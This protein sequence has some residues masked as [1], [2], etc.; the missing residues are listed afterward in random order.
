MKKDKTTNK[1][2]LKRAFYKG[3]AKKFKFLICLMLLFGIIASAFSFLRT[4]Y[5]EYAVSSAHVILNYPEISESKYPDGSRFTYY[6]FISDENLEKALSVM[7][8]NGKYLNFTVDDIREQFSIYSYLKGSAGASVSSARSEGNDFS[9]V[10]NEYRITFMQPHDYKSESVMSC[11]VSEDLSGEFLS[12]LVEVNRQKIAQT[13]GGAKGFE[14][15]TE[16]VC[17][18]NYDYIEEVSLYKTKINNII[19]YIRDLEKKQPDFIS[20]KHNLALN[21][22]RGSY[23][24]LISNSLEGIRDFVESSGISKD[25]DQTSNKIEVNIED[26]RLRFNK[27]SS[28]VVFNDFAMKNYD[29]TFTENLINVIQNEEYGLYQAR[30]KTAFDTVAVQK[31]SADENVAEYGTKIDIY[32]KELDNF[33][34]VIMTKDEH[35]RLTQKCSELIKVFEEEYASLTQKAREIVQEYYESTNEGYVTVKITPIGFIGKSLILNMGASFFIGAMLAFVLSVFV[36]S[37]SDRCR[38]MRKQRKIRRIK[39][40]SFGKEA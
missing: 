15:L 39:K 19:A 35:A 12:A 14:I 1:S 34:N 10:A 13:L 32:S 28:R 25:V 30:P 27:A 3:R 8:E 33:R 31:Y 29:Q 18:D 38:V 26:T 20:Q 11:F 2:M 37:L 5:V 9:Y 7:H 16:P 36:S 21:N 23:A 40:N 4:A 24:F 17:T 22:L 6:D